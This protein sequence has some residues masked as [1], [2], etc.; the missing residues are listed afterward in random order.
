MF[1]Q[2]SYIKY[3]LSFDPHPF[4]TDVQM[5][6]RTRQKNGELLRLSSKHGRE[7]AI[8]EIRDKKLRFRFN[9]DRHRNTDEKELWLPYVSVNDG[10]WHTVKV[11]RYG[12]IA[13]IALDGG[14]G[15]RFN[16]LLD[17]N[18]PHEQFHVDTENVVVGGDVQYIG[19]GV[20]IVDNDLVESC[21]NNIRIDGHSLPMEGESE[22]GAVI[23]FRNIMEGCP[24]N[25]PC[26]D[27][28][29]PD[30]FM[31]CMDL[32]LHGECRC[33]PGFIAD[34][35]GE[36]CLEKV[37]VCLL[38]PNELCLNGGT[39]ISDEEDNNIE[40]GFHCVCR[41][42]YSGD[43]CEVADEQPLIRLS[44]EAIMAIVICL[45]IMFSKYYYYHMPC[46]V[47]VVCHQ[48]GITRIT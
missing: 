33:G 21:I 36:R 32:W 28:V 10:Q 38:N 22:A 20:T 31:I 15:K 2:S 9:L 23:D 35:N 46:L 37:D 25:D 6:F 45:L 3:A 18:S 40:R 27:V 39:C 47:N 12:A 24:S 48:L 1:Q 5:Q 4:R 13:S 44:N 43:N 7:Y 16:E 14:W 30:P 11:M 42:G 8:L 34:E 17:F 29:C 41:S 26:Y 19:P